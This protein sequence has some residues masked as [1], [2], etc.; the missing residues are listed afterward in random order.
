MKISILGTGMVGQTIAA[1]LDSIGHDVQIGTRDP[2]STMAREAADG[3]GNPPF[4]VWAAAHPKVRLA[5]FA[6]AA[7]HGEIV[8]VALSGASALAG[9]ELAGE[10]N[11]AKKILI[12]ISNPLDF[13]RGMP[14]SLFVSNLDSLGEQIQRRF[15]AA[16][17]VKTLNTVSAH[18]MVDPRALANGDHTMFVS[19]NDA[20]ARRQVAGWLTEWFGWRDVI[21]LGDITTARG[22]EMLLPLWLRTWGAVNTPTFS[23]RV[24]R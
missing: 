10:A 13:S 17:V 22:T 23:F 4:Q 11:L 14:P 7:A 18:L 24:V 21:E 2:A 8:I 16:R 15:P 1:K 3:F 12:D 20:D 9:L 5:T 19:G 6:G